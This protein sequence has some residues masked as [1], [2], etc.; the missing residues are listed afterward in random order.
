MCGG[1]GACGCLYE[2]DE[3]YRHHVCLS[4]GPHTLTLHDKSG[5]GWLGATASLHQTSAGVVPLYNRYGLPR[6]HASMSW[7]DARTAARGFRL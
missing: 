1:A 3:T 6:D 4:P 5:F 7:A 2:K